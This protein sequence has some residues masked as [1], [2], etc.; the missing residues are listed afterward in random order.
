MNR[1]VRSL[2]VLSTLLL[3]GE[4]LAD[5]RFETIAP[6]VERAI[7]ETHSRTDAPV[8]NVWIYRPAASRSPSLPCVLVAASGSN[9]LNGAALNVDLVPEHVPY[10][11]N[12][13]VVVAYDVDGAIDTQ[14]PADEYVKLLK[15][16]MLSEGGVANAHEALRKAIEIEPRI[17]PSRLFAAGHGSAANVALALAADDDRIRAVV[18]FSP[19]DDVIARIG[20]PSIDAMNT[21]IDGYRA[22]LER[23]QPLALAERIKAQLMIF[24]PADD[25]I[26]PI[27]A[28]RVLAEKLKTNGNPPHLIEPRTGGHVEAM[29]SSGLKDASTWLGELASRL[30]ATRPTSNSTRP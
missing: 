17:D 27:A 18:A 7:V 20:N 10:V 19:L 23:T 2:G 1:I 13:C 30:P 22:F 6:G 14:T 3:C 12:G 25:P 28:T 8:M 4:A 21:A 9:G 16:F 15:S 24:H 26:A 5:A 11:Q 29:L